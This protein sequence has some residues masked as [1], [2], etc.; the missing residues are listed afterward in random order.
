M[1]RYRAHL[2]SEVPRCRTGEGEGRVDEGA[3]ATDAGADCDAQC[4]Q[5][6]LVV[7]VVPTRVT[8]STHPLP[9]KS[10]LLFH[11]FTTFLCWRLLR[12]FWYKLF[13]S[14]GPRECA[15]FPVLFVSHAPVSSSVKQTVEIKTL[16]YLRQI[17]CNKSYVHTM[18][19]EA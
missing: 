17:Q 16:D 10:V 8:T 2:R 9:S 12:V 15:N 11:F 3:H 7:I 14:H 1:E 6:G 5:E 4:L 19:Y 13:C 18:L